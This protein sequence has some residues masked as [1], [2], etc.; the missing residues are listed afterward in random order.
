[1]RSMTVG[2]VAAV[3][4]TASAFAETIITAE[5]YAVDSD[6]VLESALKEVKS[7]T[8]DTINVAGDVIK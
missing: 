2:I 5:D 1:M 6:V 4:M 7:I 3:L 8:G